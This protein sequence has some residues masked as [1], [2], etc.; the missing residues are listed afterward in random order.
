[1]DVDIAKVAPMDNE[2]KKKLIAEGR[3]FHCKRQGHMSCNCPRKKEGI[4][5]KEGTDGKGSSSIKVINEDEE[6]EMSKKKDKKTDLLGKFKA[7]TTEEKDDLI[8]AMMEDF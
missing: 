2:E 5:K 1:M 4:S 7:L 8:G 6:E 3:C